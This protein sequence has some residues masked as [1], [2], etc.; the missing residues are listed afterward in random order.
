MEIITF[1]E[2]TYV[3][4]PP[5]I[6]QIIKVMDRCQAACSSSEGKTLGRD[7]PCVFSYLAIQDVRKG[8]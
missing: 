6:I 5:S 3:Y 8:C 2:R 7:I 1:R 4:L